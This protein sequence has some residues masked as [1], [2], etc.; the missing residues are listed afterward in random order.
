M[1]H[2]RRS[3][4][5]FF[6]IFPYELIDPSPKV[7]RCQLAKIESFHRSRR[8]VKRRSIFNLVFRSRFFPLPS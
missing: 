4:L 5:F 3:N 8:D 1:K 7:I 2:S 6:Q